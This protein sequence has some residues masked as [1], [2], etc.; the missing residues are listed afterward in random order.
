MACRLFSAKQ[1]PELVF[2]NCS[3]IWI[4]IQQF[5]TRND[6]KNVAHFSLGAIVLNNVVGIATSVITRNKCQFNQLGQLCASVQFMKRSRYMR[7]F[8]FDRCFDD[9]IVRAFE[10]PLQSRGQVVDLHF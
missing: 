9:R 3:E 2:T 4:K 5:H 6:F 10:R 8:P 1:L 7:F